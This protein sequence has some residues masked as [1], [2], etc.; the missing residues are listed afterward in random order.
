MAALGKTE[1]Q[2]REGGRAIRIGRFPFRLNGKAL[3][4]CETEGQAKVVADARTGEILG[5]HMVGP[6]VTELIGE[7]AIARGLEATPLEVARAVH[8]H[9]TLSEVIAEAARAV[10]GEPIHL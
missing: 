2:A 4:L 1:A 9:P 7:F 5:V 8:P 3:A 10:E 6:D